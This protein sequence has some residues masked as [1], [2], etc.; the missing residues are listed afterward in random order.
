MPVVAISHPLALHKLTCLRRSVEDCSQ[1]VFIQLMREIGMVMASEVMRHTHA[2]LSKKLLKGVN[3]PFEGCILENGN[4]V[5]V[6]VLRSGITF[7][8]GMDEVIGAEYIGHIGIHHDEESNETREYLFALPDLN[9][10]ANRKI[11]L[12]D[13]VVATGA[14]AVRAIKS[15]EEYGIDSNNIILVSLIVG[16]VGQEQL[17]KHCPNTLTFCCLNG[18]EVKGTSV[19]RGLGSVSARQFR[20]I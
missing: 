17:S 13:P 12:I 3:V 19:I 7:A 1:R 20:T 15:L 11:F 6:P 2:H 18:E 16:D 9:L 8:Q 10:I 5:L 14:T 4:P